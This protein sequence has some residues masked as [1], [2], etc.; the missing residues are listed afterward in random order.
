MK[1]WLVTF[2]THLYNEDAMELAKQNNLEIVNDIFRDSIKLDE[3]ANDIPRLT[4]K[5]AKKTKA[6]KVVEKAP[7]EKGED[8]DNTS[9]NTTE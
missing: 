7:V 1:K 3:I 2:P 8:N 5:G 6:K 9:N 4:L